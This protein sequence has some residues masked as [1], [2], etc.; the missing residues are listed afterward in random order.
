M[1]AYVLGAARALGEGGYYTRVSPREARDRPAVPPAG[2]YI[3]G[4]G[5]CIPRGAVV[6]D[7]AFVLFFLLFF[8][9][10][11]ERGSRILMGG[12]G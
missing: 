8:S 5:M 9:D 2:E 12:E 3:I 4:L 7:S 10:E 1:R 11:G 6:D